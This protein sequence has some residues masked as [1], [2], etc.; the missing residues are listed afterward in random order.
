MTCNEIVASVRGAVERLR[1]PLYTQ[2]RK[3]GWTD[4]RRLEILRYFESLEVDLAANRK[5]PFFSL[6]RA[7]DGMGISQGDL[8]EDLCRVNS[9]VNRMVSSTP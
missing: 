9:V 3:C 4:E 2:D 1:Q 7:L 6:I 8:L 5:V